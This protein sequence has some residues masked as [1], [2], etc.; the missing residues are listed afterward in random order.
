MLVQKCSFGYFLCSKGLIKAEKG[1][2]F[3]LG[4]KDLAGALKN[5]NGLVQNEL[6]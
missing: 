4:L 3:S 6:L 2:F 5:K 1:L